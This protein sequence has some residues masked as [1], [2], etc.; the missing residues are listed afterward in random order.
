MSSTWFTIEDS[1]GKLLPVFN[2]DGSRGFIHDSDRVYFGKSLYFRR[3][4]IGTNGCIFDRHK[5]KITYLAKVAMNNAV[6]NHDS[7]Q[8]KYIQYYQALPDLNT[9]KNKNILIMGAIEK[10]CEIEFQ[11][12][13]YSM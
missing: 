12:D 8:I 7:M 10:T 2:Y 1:E 6:F 9:L 13:N 3:L 4:A 5:D 11:I